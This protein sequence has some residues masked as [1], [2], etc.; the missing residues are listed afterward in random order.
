MGYLKVK[1][2]ANFMYRNLLKLNTM[3]KLTSL[4]KGIKLAALAFASLTIH[5]SSFAQGDV[6]QLLKAGATDASKLVQ[7]YTTPFFRGFGVGLNGGWYNTAKPHGLGRFDVTFNMNLCTVPTEDQTYDAAALGFTAIRLD[8]PA[9]HIGQTLAGEINPKNNPVYVLELDNT[10]TP[11]PGDKI[12]VA[13]FDA[14]PG[15][16]LPYSGAPTVQLAVGL[17]KKTEVMVRYM[18]TVS[19]GKQGDI[20]LVG[21]GLKHDIKQWIPVV[22]KMP[23]DMSAYFGYTKMNLNYGLDLKPEAG[24]PN[25]TGNNG[26]YADQAMDLETKSTTFGL[27]L[28]K[29]LAILTVYG[30]ANYQRSSTTLGLNGDYPITSFEGTVGDPNFGSK[31]VDKVSNP[32]NF[33]VDGA[34]GMTGTIGARLK[35][36]VL[37]FQGAYT[38]GKYPMVTAGVGLNI[39]WK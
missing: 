18:P 21:F 17:I 12:E 16:G 3:K 10:A 7:A 22:S 5:Q 1:D 11:V 15:A 25:K 14:P 31:V 38:F 13:R 4:H 32:V 34:N 26:V 33:T 20:G 37:T 36:L 9:N 39:D 19:L 24:V 30:A 27:I 35:L 8:N 6:A 29:K 23:F 28:S 2:F